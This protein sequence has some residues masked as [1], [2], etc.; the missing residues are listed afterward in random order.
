MVIDISGLKSSEPIRK[1]VLTA[2]LMRRG[3]IG[4][5]IRLQKHTHFNI[6]ASCMVDVMMWSRWKL[7]LPEVLLTEGK[8]LKKMKKKGGKGKVLTSEPKKLRDCQP[9]GVSY[10]RRRFQG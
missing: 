4:Y 6:L 1:F 9:D 10:R 8:W 3:Y 7:A 2:R 5:S